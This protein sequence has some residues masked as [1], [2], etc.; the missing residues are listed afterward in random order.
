MKGTV[1]L[2]NP[3]SP[4]PNRLFSGVS[5]RGY[6]GRDL[7]LM[8][9]HYLPPRL[10]KSGALPLLPLYAFMSWTRSATLNTRQGGWDGRC[11]GMEHS[12]RVSAYKVMMR[13][14]EG[15][16][17]LGT[18]RHGGKA[19]FFNNQLDALIIQIYSVIK[20]CMFRVSSLPIIRSF[21]L[22]IRHW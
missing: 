17:P 12:W 6:S 21:I 13:K 8:P 5:S 4:P 22:Y 15:E 10:R 20:I 14:L 1:N 11:E 19:F 9:H 18:S 7:K 2:Y 16:G 3:H